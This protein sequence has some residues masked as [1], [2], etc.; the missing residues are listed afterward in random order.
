MNTR[1]TGAQPGSPAIP[2]SAPSGR[3]GTRP[4]AR[5]GEPKGVMAVVSRLL[6]PG[7]PPMEIE[8]VV[9]EVKSHHPKADA[10]EIVRAYEL[11]RMA[12]EGQRRK[13]GELFIEHPVGVA[14][15]LASLGMDATTVVAAFLHDVV[16]DT[17]LGLDDIRSSF[18]EEVAAI[19]DGL[20]KIDKI[21]FGSREQEQAGNLRKMIVAMA[22]DLRVLIIKLADRL[23]NMRT[24]RGH[25]SFKQEAIATE[26]LEIYAPLADRLGMQKI[27]AD[28]EDLAFRTLHPKRYFEIE[29]MVAQRQ[30]E[31]EQ[32]L[33]RV[34]EQVRFRLR[35]ARIKA[36]VSGRPKHF[37]S[38]YHKM[39]ARKREF[40]Q[41]FD[42]IAVRIIVDNIRD[43]YA[44][45]GAIHSLWNPIPGRFKDYIAM[46]KFNLY[47][48]LHTT[49]IGLEGKP[50]EIQIRTREMHRVA[51]WGVAAHWRYKEDMGAKGS[52]EQA[53]WMRR[54]L[55]LRETEDDREFLD[56]VRLDLFADEVFVFTPKGDVV[57]LPKGATPIDFAFAIH[58]QVGYACTGARVDGRLVPLDYQLSSGETVQI[59]LGRAAG[60]SRDWLKTVIT[61]RARTKI[62]QWFTKE[63]R[64]EA[65]AEGKDALTKAIRRAGLPLQR[66]LSDESLDRVAAELKFPGLEALCV[67]LGE[68]RAS[69]QSVVARLVRQHTPVEAEEE[70]PRPQRVRTKGR[71]TEGVLVQ[72]TG[73]VMVKL[74]RCCMPVPGDA[75]LGFVTRGRGISVHRPECPN[76][77]YLSE[78]GARLVEVLWD[79]R[80]SGLFPVSIQVEALDRPKLLRDVTTAISDFSVNITSAT[81]AT[82]RG[83]ARLRFTFELAEPSQLDTILVTVR[84]VEA[85]YDAYRLT[86][87]YHQ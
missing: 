86:P 5:P 12:H 4:D 44:A 50:L 21:R 26:T 9:R 56:S 27:K 2:T 69:V 58:T 23:H 71:P 20:T 3:G 74:A 22:K 38:I 83:I 54:M 8:D 77:K 16:E 30:P 33:E 31:R 24:L 55:E 62:R 7:A 60:P 80:A 40:S 49:A 41:I 47:R 18:G 1:G 51:E 25:A 79:P 43:C 34:V 28:L 78:D 11:A 61:P 67:G 42:L 46:P 45:V 72:G 19:I 87:G 85:V 63:R 66:I 13:S 65:I 35:Q 75:I 70:P 14:R 6:P 15:I 82:G 32:Y 36:E 73:D 68:G 81:S 39:V 48:S 64:S 84:R 17:D 53:A 57:S 29:Q 10:K 59:V 52:D 76:I 37:Y